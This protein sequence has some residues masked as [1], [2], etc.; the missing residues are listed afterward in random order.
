[1]NYSNNEKNEKNNFTKDNFYK[2]Y[3]AVMNYSQFTD[4][5]QSQTRES[6]IQ[7][8]NNLKSTNKNRQFL[9]NNATKIM[10]KEWEILSE[11]NPLPN[12]CV[13]NYSLTQSINDQYDEMKLYNSI[14]TNNIPEK[15]K[16]VKMIDYRMCDQI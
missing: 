13:H 16:C 15:A 8:I 5:R 11:F 7:N 6:N 12:V 4:Y 9:Q 10:N 14:N 1:M 2:T 3:P